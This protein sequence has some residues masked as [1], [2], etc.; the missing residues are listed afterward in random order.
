MVLGAQVHFEAG[1][2]SVRPALTQGSVRSPHEPILSSNSHRHMVASFPR[3][4]PK[5]PELFRVHFNLRPACHFIQ[6]IITF[7]IISF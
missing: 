7:S 1:A 2:S 5:L 6:A 3:H 4:H